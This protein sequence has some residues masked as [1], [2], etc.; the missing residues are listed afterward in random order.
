MVLTKQIVSINDRFKVSKLLQKVEQRQPRDYHHRWFISRISVM[1]GDKTVRPFVKRHLIG[2][3]V[4]QPTDFHWIWKKT[5]LIAGI[6]EACRTFPIDLWW[7][8]E[9]EFR[10][11]TNGSTKACEGV[12]ERYFQTALI[13]IPIC[14]YNF[15]SK[16]SKF[17]T[18]FESEF[19]T[20]GICSQ[21]V[22]Y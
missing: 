8:A 10:W 22:H 13:E 2:P 9:F 3:P 5:N 16:L 19:L 20:N 7:S 1:I 12:M 11:R 21:Q 14:L 15:E 4:T 18:D 6:V 17:L